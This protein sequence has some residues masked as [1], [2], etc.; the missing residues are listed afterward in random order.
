MEQIISPVESD[1]MEAL[2]NGDEID[3]F[4]DNFGIAE[5]RYSKFYHNTPVNR[6]RRNIMYDRLPAWELS[7]STEYDHAFDRLR[8]EIVQVA[9]DLPSRRCHRAMQKIRALE[10]TKVMHSMKHKILQLNKFVKHNDIK[11]GRDLKQMY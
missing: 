9:N 3:H 11:S 4:S 6:H 10:E 1:P 5:K 7:Y 2:E 8:P